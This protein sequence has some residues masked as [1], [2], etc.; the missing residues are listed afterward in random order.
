MFRS[1]VKG[2]KKLA[3]GESGGAPASELFP[4]VDPEV[5]GEDCLRD[6]DNC[7]THYPKGFKIEETDDIYGGVKAWSTHVLVATGKSD[8]S[9]NVADEKGSVMQAIDRA[10]KPSNGRL[11][12]SAS[13]M[14][15][16]THS[17]D[18]SEPTT[19]LLLPAFAVV[20]NVTPASVPA[21][22]S[23]Y[24]NRSP[25]NTSALEPVSAAAIPASLPP[26][27]LHD[28]APKL[29]G[30]TSHPSPHSVLILL[31]SQKTRDARC[32]QSAPLIKK[33]LQRH[34]RP[35]GLYRDLDDERPGGVG[36]YFISHVG[37]HKYSAN[38]II[39]RRPDPFGLD[40][41]ERVNLKDGES[42]TPR[43]RDPTKDDGPDA[44]AG[45]CIWLAR[46]KPE[47]CEGIVK[48]TVLQ[49]KVVKPEQQLRGGFDRARG[50][51]SW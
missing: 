13:N 29:H 1:L 25:T 3:I 26:P 50:L 32:G 43:K 27:G 39:Y 36:I 22:V 38:V 34:L 31:C 19:L 45:Q 21:L 51:M 33:E 42:L 5:D 10:D 18:Y 15:T 41:L 9:H 46:V 2:A 28:P 40:A 23:E 11:M 35:L 24:I 8:W 20:H 7:P 14:P 16:P 44:G 4:K 30:L 47:D 6:C 48:Y 17:S 49:G 37:G 12:L